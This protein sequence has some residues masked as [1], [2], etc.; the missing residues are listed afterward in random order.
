MQNLGRTIGIAILVV[1][2]LPSSAYAATQYIT[3]E[4]VSA[5]NQVEQALKENKG[6]ASL[7]LEGQ[8]AYLSLQYTSSEPMRIYAVP[9]DTNGSY[10]PTDFVVFTLDAATERSVLIDLTVSPGWTPKN[11]IWNINALTEH[12]NVAAEFLTVDFIPAST[13]KQATTMIRQLFTPEAYTPSTFHALRGYRVFAMS[14]VPILGLLTLIIATILIIRNPRKRIPTYVCVLICGS[15][16]Y[17]GRFAIDLLRFSFEHLREYKAGTYDEAGS[18]YEIAKTLRAAPATSSV[19]VCRDGTDYKEKILRYMVYPLQVT[20]NEDHA[21]TAMYAVVMNKFD[22]SY[23]SVLNCGAL[24]KP[25]TK[26]KDYPDGSVLFSLS[27]P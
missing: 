18:V 22:W 9:L 3:P 26:I 6:R 10:S 15:L 11:H 13:V 23:E 12:E 8:G 24:K 5:S 4:I 16:L 14:I 2:A 17:Q 1:L 27:Q 7:S 21:A 20:S 25:A 19:Y